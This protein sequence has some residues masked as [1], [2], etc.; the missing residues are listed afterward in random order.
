MKGQRAPIHAEGELREIERTAGI[1]T[2]SA[3]DLVSTV[4]T[5]GFSIA[6]KQRVQ[7][8]VAATLLSRPH[9]QEMKIFYQGL[10]S[11]EGQAARVISISTL[12]EIMK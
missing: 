1:R 10:P 7:R 12:E 2:L 4:H 9:C 6:H 8:R 11:A 5:V 3:V